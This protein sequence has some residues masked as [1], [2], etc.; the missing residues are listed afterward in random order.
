MVMIMLMIT[1]EK[2]WK[3][4]KPVM[5][6][7]RL[8]N[9]CDVMAC[10]ETGTPS[11]KNSCIVSL[12]G[13]WPHQKP[14]L[15]KC[16]HSSAWQPKNISPPKM[17]NNIHTTTSF[18]AL[19]WP[20]STAST[21]VTELMMRINVIKPTNTNGAFSDTKGNTLNTMDGAGHVGALK[22]KAP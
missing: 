13:I 4:W 10:C 17:V 1:P 14:S 6:K 16:D 9:W 12:F 22:R 11:A 20:A 2:T 5:V 15:C 3:P 8:A 21:M 19:R 7:N 18:F